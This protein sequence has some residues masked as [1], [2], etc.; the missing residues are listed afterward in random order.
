MSPTPSSS[1]PRIGVRRAARL[2]VAPVLCVATLGS[3]APA[4]AETFTDSDATGDMVRYV[5]GGP[6]RPASDRSVN[7]V[8]AT[9]LTHSTTRIRLHVQ[10][11]DLR[12]STY[13]AVL[14]QVVTDEGARRGVFL[15]ADPERAGTRVRMSNGRGNRVRCSI[16]HAVDYAAETATVGFSRRCAGEPGWVRARVGV[17][18]ADDQ[19]YFDDALRDRPLDDSD[20]GYALSPRV[21]RVEVQ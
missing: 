13:H 6:L 11:V 2:V 3:P 15:E 19:L 20:R 10:Y 18:S 1:S 12:R 14:F 17:M 21:H 5:D 9:T 7:D 8:T 16:H 4:L